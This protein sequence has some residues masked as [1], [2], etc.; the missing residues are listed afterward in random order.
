MTTTTQPQRTRLD[1]C[2]ILDETLARYA[3]DAAWLGIAWVP[4][5]RNH[6]YHR[7]RASDLEAWH[8]QQTQLLTTTYADRLPS[9][10]RQY[11]LKNLKRTS[12]NYAAI[13]ATTNLKPGQNLYLWGP[14]GNGKTHL[15]VATGK[16]LAEQGKRVAFYGVVSLFAQLRASFAPDGPTRPNLEAPD[17]L[18]LDDLGKVKPTEFVYQE[19]YAALEHRWANEKT[20]IFTA[21]HRPADAARHLSPDN[22]SALAILSRM[23]SGTVIEVRGRDE[24]LPA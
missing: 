19:F 7:N 24:R 5:D 2:E 22:E 9:R 21:N 18:I 6:E 11:D 13:D 20:T 8:A 4:K 17:A 15:A 12:G 16:R 1:E 10:Y 3:G 23:A 14:P